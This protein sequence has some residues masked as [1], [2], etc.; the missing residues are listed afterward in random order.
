MMSTADEI[1]LL[2]PEKEE[3]AQLLLKIQRHFN[4]SVMYSQNCVPLGS[5]ETVT[6]EL[7][8]EDN[9]IPVIIISDG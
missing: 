8:D 5:Y 4:S 9:A 7:I 2:V 1:E 6:I 3:K